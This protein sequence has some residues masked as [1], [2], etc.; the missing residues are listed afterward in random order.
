MTGNDREFGNVRTISIVSLLIAACGP[1]RP[2]PEPPQP[3]MAPMAPT[4]A[5]RC[6]G[7]DE[8]QTCTAYFRIGEPETPQASCEVACV[9]GGAAC[10]DGQVCTMVTNGPGFV[11]RAPVAVPTYARAVSNVATLI[12]VW[13]AVK[14]THP[15][16]YTDAVDWDAAFM[17]ALDAAEKAGDDAALIKA[18]DAMIATLGDPLTTLRPEGNGSGSAPSG[19]LY[20]IENPGQ[21]DEFLLVDL[22]QGGMDAREPL[23][24]LVGVL[25]RAK[26][27]IFDLRDIAPDNLWTVDF[28]F[29]GF[30]SALVAEP[31]ELPTARELRHQGYKPHDGGADY[32]YW[33]TLVSALPAMVNPSAA[34]EPARV[35]FLVGETQALPSIAIPLWHAGLA[36]IVGTTAVDARALVPTSTIDVADGWQLIVRAGDVTF[37]GKPVAISADAIAKDDALALARKLLA[38]PGK[39]PRQPGPSRPVMTPVWRPDNAYAGDDVPG[40]RLR[41]LAV[42]RLW[43]VIRFF[44]P[45][46][47]L[48]GD[49]EPVLPEFIAA[50]ADA[51][52]WETYIKTMARMVAR[53][54]DTHSG[55]SGKRYH[56]QFGFARPPFE[57]KIIDGAVVIVAVKDAAKSPRVAVGDV[58]IAVDGT[59]IAEAYARTAP[60]VAASR[61]EGHALRTV[62]TAISGQPGQ[63]RTYTLAASDRR[64]KQV[65]VTLERP[66]PDEPGA[67]GEHKAYRKLTDDIGYVD[68]R[69]LT[70]ADVDPMFAALVDTRAIIFDM[71]G[72][73][74]G[75][76][77]SIGPRLA[78]PVAKLAVARYDVPIV[79]HPDAKSSLTTEHR[80]LSLDGGREPGYP[81][82]TVML[83]DERTISQAEYTGMIFEAANGTE[84]VGTETAGAN[85]DVTSLRL[86]GGVSVRFTGA[87]IGFADGRQLQ[88]VGIVPD[89]RAAPTIAG[90]RAGKD[91]VLDAAIAHLRE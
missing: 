37:Q 53:V 81:G 48:I 18:V 89:V 60:Y 84:F 73:P 38:R 40:R 36:V 70:V 90:L 19:A 42:A 41:L 3:P 9:P 87:D 80:Q 74:K 69:V 27:V 14:F 31:V 15:G 32:A 33:S 91:E 34:R 39:K 67:S 23:S 51:D 1:A 30:H 6:G 63:T 26:K 49:W 20:R 68:L 50:V 10:S 35:A 43:T 71:R 28:T 82:R 72:Y 44:Y 4:T 45:Y 59:P 86:P 29:E 66:E 56:E 76:A 8:G 24:Q 55:M 64:H 79:A 5:D 62:V 16:V 83:I 17:N 22:G 78:G 75:T 11:C 52:T 61:P 25:P 77:W 65:T 54:A 58:L 13:G 7:C 21:A 46:R 47:H 12:K 85:G 88:R 57:V 2:K